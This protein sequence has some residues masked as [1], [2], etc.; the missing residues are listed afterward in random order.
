MDPT[1]MAAAAAERIR[2]GFNSL[3]RRRGEEE[4]REWRQRDGHDR[5]AAASTLL[6]L[7]LWQGRV[8]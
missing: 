5:R 1:T 2:R 8:G 7:Q 6:A 3:L 4:A